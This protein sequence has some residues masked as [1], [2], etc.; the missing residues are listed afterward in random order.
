M[1]EQ[2]FGEIPIE[3]YLHIIGHQKKRRVGR[4]ARIAAMLFMCTLCIAAGEY[5]QPWSGRRAPELP[6]EQ[7]LVV[8]EDG[9]PPQKLRSAAEV[10]RR[11]CKRSI[12]ALS[13]LKNAGDGLD[14]T[15]D[16]I[17][18]GIAKRAQQAR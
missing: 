3:D 17:L 4:L 12:N 11:Y 1:S 8:I 6:F 10:L 2:Q 14:A 5:L 9:A 13:G 7:A 16:A 18:A 15:A